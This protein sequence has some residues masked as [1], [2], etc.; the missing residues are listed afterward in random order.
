MVLAPPQWLR[1][2]RFY[3]FVRLLLFVLRY[4]P[5]CTITSWYRDPERNALVGGSPRSLHLL[6]LA[7]DLVGPA[8]ELEAVMRIWRAAGLDAVDEGDHLHLE[9]DGPLL[10]QLPLAA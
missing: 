10:R 4:A 9:L 7:I 2:Q 5:N 3:V 8:V 6:G 1:T